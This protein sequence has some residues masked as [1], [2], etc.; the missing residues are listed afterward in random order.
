MSEHRPKSTP[1]TTSLLH[2]DEDV[3]ATAEKT[4]ALIITRG[5]PL[6]DIVITSSTQHQSLVDFMNDDL[7]PAKKFI[8][9]K[10]DPMREKLHGL[11]KDSIQNIKDLCDPIDRIETSIR[12]SCKQWDAHLR[13]LEAEANRKRDEEIRERLDA[14]ALA[15]AQQLADD[16]ADDAEVEAAIAD[17]V[18][19]TST[20]SI[21]ASLPPR[22][23]QGAVASGMSSRAPLR[24][25][26]VLDIDKVHR[27]FL[28][29]DHAKVQ[30][31]ISVNGKAAELMV[32]K[33]GAI[34][35]YEESSVAFRR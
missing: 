34:E 8:L 19:G 12:N 17:V 14:E 15:N 25:Y 30:A 18:S 4:A 2:L 10:L 27:N 31:L 9:S 33:A 16:G 3:R 32:G 35:Y 21:L 26:R 29:I 1:A 20:S 11:W 22:P 13:Q 28:M 24:K 5:K 7:L 23:V 6:T